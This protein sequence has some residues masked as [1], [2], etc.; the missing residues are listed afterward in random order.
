LVWCF[1]GWR[2][3]KTGDYLFP[4]T[5]FLVVFAFF[6]FSTGKREL[7]ILPLYP[8]AAIITGKL[9]VDYF[10]GLESPFIRRYM[11]IS[12]IV[13]ICVM[14][15]AG[16]LP[17]FIQPKFNK[18][19]DFRP[20]VSL[21]PFIVCF[22]V[23]G[24]LLFFLRHKKKAYFILILIMM[25]WG[26][27]YTTRSVLPVLNQ[28]KSAKPLCSEILALMKSGDEL[29]IYRKE[30][31]A[32]NFYTG[33]YPIRGI[34]TPE[35]LISVFKT[36]KRIFCLIQEDDFEKLKNSLAGVNPIKR[37]D[38]GHREYMVI[39]NIQKSPL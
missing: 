25:S 2:E 22:W 9:W 16:T 18:Y 7:Y 34:K 24:L 11:K 4:C 36:Q 15:I 13:L 5:W 21:I 35:L 37:A 29:V 20:Q 23:T 32:F 17:L 8:A 19:Q 12:L 30:A 14:L 26:I 33:I 6:T 3:K 38:I 39:S 27:L 31:S 1:Q 10:A 28:F